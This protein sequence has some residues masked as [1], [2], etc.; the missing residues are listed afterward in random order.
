MNR[1]CFLPVHGTL[2]MCYNGS[3]PPLGTRTSN[4]R[5]PRVAP[6]LR[7]RCYW[8]RSGY[9]GIWATCL[10]SLLF[11]FVLLMFGPN[12]HLIMDFSWTWLALWIRGSDRTRLMMDSCGCMI[13]WCARVRHFIS[14]SRIILLCRWHRVYV[15]IL[16]LGF[17]INSLWPHFPPLIL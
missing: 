7:K 5:E 8:N 17:A 1:N 4:S 13:S 12:F 16:P 6:N 2:A 14:T 9:I 15:V 3:V 10:Y 11:T